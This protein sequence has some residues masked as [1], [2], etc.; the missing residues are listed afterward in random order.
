MDDP[1]NK[2]LLDRLSRMA[3]DVLFSIFLLQS[4]DR[5]NGFLSFLHAHALELTAKSACLSLGIDYHGLKNGH[6]LKVIYEK[7][8][9]EVPEITPLVPDAEAFE[10]YR[11]VWIPTEPVL[12][13]DINLSYLPEPPKLFMWEVAYLIDNI[14]NLKYGFD[15]KK[16]YVSVFRIEYDGFNPHFQKLIGGT[17]KIYKTK[18]L[19]HKM[20]LKM[21]ATFNDEKQIEHLLKEVLA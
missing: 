4:S 21:Y 9:A 18:E 6:D 2:H 13:K 20:R 8:G 19:D 7:I 10:K 3:D 1:T 12:K 16:V 5:G 15:K 11:D 17:R 14:T